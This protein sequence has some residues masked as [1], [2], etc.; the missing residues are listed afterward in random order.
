MEHKE[1]AHVK[2][3]EKLKKNLASLNI[4]L[5]ESDLNRIAQLPQLKHINI[6]LLSRVIKHVRNQNER[7]FHRQFTKIRAKLIKIDEENENSKNTIEEFINL[8][9][10]KVIF[11]NVFE[12]TFYGFTTD[13]QKSDFI[14]NAIIYYHS[15]RDVTVSPLFSDMSIPGMT[16]T[17]VIP[18][19]TDA[20]RY[21]KMYIDHT[22]GFVMS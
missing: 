13:H 4:E 18:Y 5:S 9:S 20:I 21:I 7:L 19:Q 14:N 6:E 10:D 17:K 8:L 22:R 2:T 12:N 16:A 3:I 11:L 1:G 15:L